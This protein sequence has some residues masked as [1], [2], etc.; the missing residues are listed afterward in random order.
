MKWKEAG[1]IFSVAILGVLIHLLP[2]FIYGAHPLGYDTGFYRRYLIDHQHILQNVPGLGYDTILPKATYDFLH[3]LKLQTDLILYGSVIALALLGTIALYFLVRATSDK[4]TAILSAFLFTLSPIQYFGYW[5][6]LY[7]N[8]Y[9]VL[10]LLLTAF[11]IQK[12][13]PW[14]YVGAVMLVLCHETTSVIFLLAL[15]VFWIINK[16]M[17]RE[18]TIM[19]ALSAIVFCLIHFADIGGTILN[20]P[21]ASFSS[22]SEYAVFSFP[23]FL[24]AIAGFKQ[25][26][27]NMRGSFF[28]AFSA[29]S[30]AYPIL[31][32]PFY[33]RI[34]IFTDIAVA[35]MAAFGVVY[36]WEA[37]R[38][39]PNQLQ[40]YLFAV[41]L[42]M[43]L[44]GTGCL[45]GNRIESLSPMVSASTLRELKNIDAFVP[46]GSYLLTET[47]LAPWAEGWSHDHIIAPGLLFDRHSL[48]EWTAFWGETD[49]KK[50]I[51]FLNS[52][53]KP[54]YFFVPSNDVPTYAPDG[55]TEKM[56]DYIYKYTCE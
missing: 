1:G 43:F 18:T 36:F 54:L 48:A 46:K 4:K 24:L 49:P 9:G 45:L 15:A 23:L 39:A 47:M 53:D 3:F 38:S 20:L 41:T 32:L 8:M 55:C 2:F 16:K 6:M 34:F 35:V 31:H 22:W 37:A 28:L 26:M 17:R 42:G 5:A 19:F 33:Q 40:K 51:L 11:L 50:R 30:I 12:R 13:S 52:F 14:M 25:Y 10:I 27:K 7:K 29:V 44:I 56:T 21:H